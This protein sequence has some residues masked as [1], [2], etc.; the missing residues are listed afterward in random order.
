ME[1]FARGNS[2]YINNYQASCV[3]VLRLQNHSTFLDIQIDPHL[4]GSTGRS[5]TALAVVWEFADAGEVDN[6]RLEAAAGS[7]Q[8]QVTWQ[9]KC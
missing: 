8:N 5:S 4:P 9:L 2:C 7:C 6:C 1:E 3:K